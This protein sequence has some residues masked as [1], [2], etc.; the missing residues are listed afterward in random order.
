MRRDGWTVRP[1]VWTH[2]DR[3]FATGEI[4]GDEADA[5]L[6]VC[7]SRWS[8]RNDWQLLRF[9]ARDLSASRY[10]QISDPAKRSRGPKHQHRQPRLVSLSWFPDEAELVKLRPISLRVLSELGPQVKQVIVRH[11]LAYDLV[12]RSHEDSPDHVVALTARRYRQLVHIGETSPAARIAEVT[13]TPVRTIH[14]RLRLARERGLLPQSQPGSRGGFPGDDGARAQLVELG[15]LIAPELDRP[16]A[17]ASK[18]TFATRRTNRTGSPR[19]RAPI[20]SRR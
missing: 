5:T 19:G 6:L 1:D 17:T 20:G 3:Y 13:G 14:N 10:R 11:V 7:I 8:P 15:D 16:A 2:V 12:E 18:P 9:E 4:H